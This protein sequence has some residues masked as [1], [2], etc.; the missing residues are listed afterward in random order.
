MI[1]HVLVLYQFAQFN[2]LYLSVPE[3]LVETVFTLYFCFTGTQRRRSSNRLAF[4]AVARKRKTAGRFL[5]DGQLPG[6]QRNYTNDHRTR[7]ATL[8]YY[9]LVFHDINLLACADVLC[10]IRRLQ[11]FVSLQFYVRVRLRFFSSWQEAREI[12]FKFCKY[13]REWTLIQKT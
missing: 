1:L 13:K 5:Q 11:Q 2:L 12:T 3:K 9:Q 7:Y 6:F 4:R 10:A 8:R